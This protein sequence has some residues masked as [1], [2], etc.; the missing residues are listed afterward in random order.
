MDAAP[1]PGRL[2]ARG[3]ATS[4]GR[5][6][7]KTVL[8][9]FRAFLSH[10]LLRYIN[11]VIFLLVASIALRVA[12]SITLALRNI[13]FLG[14]TFRYFLQSLFFFRDEARVHL[15]HLR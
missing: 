12:I 5:D 9:L 3:L 2:F 8:Q 14:R 1:G 7:G 6:A 10:L 11:S 4:A 15:L 13:R